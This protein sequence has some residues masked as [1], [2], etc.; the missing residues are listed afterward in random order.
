MSRRRQITALLEAWM[1]QVLFGKSRRAGEPG[2]GSLTPA[3][4]SQGFLSW[5]FA[6]I[7]FEGS[8]ARAFV[9]GTLA[10]VV[11]LSTIALVGELDDERERPADRDLVRSGPIAPLT[12]V[13]AR[14]LR[15]ALVTVLYSGG[16]AIAPAI[17]SG[18]K[19][20]DFFVVPIGFIASACLLSSAMSALLG[21]TTR[22][23][24][25]VIGA[26]RASS[27]SS[28]VRAALFGGG[29][30]AILL[31]MRAMLSNTSA[32]PGGRALLELLPMTWCA[33]AM[34]S[35]APRDLLLALAFP[36]ATA[37]LVL[38][39][40]RLSPRSEGGTKRKR[41]M[42]QFV[43]RAIVTDP[44]RR[45]ITSFCLAMLS[46]ER[47]FRLRALPLLGLPAA[48][49]LIALRADMGPDRLPWFLALIH[50]LP[51][52]YLPFLL[53]FAPYAEQPRASWLV[54]LHVTN[55]LAA[56]RRG[57]EIAF[58]VLCVPVQLVLLV[59]DASL[60]ETSVALF[61]T[62]GSL[63]IA[64]LALPLSARI[65]TRP[66]FAEDP[67]ELELPS[68]FGSSLG[69]A[70]AATGAA[71]ALEA[72]MRRFGPWAALGIFALGAGVLFARA[73]GGAPATRE[74]PKPSEI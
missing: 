61:T 18:F 8:S 69:F 49:V 64:W 3:V 32:F 38:L 9:A 13:L 54:E 46:R 52:A 11:L 31:G 5:G 6:A 71:F 67:D 34:L 27:F 66:A 48:A 62:L 58:A 59:V 7:A 21:A 20:G 51:L 33:D 43:L 29:F 56:Y 36:A 50:Q 60:R 70:V 73:R 44:K 23:I 22:T 42:L 53:W 10:F 47:S 16:L 19:T 68:D 65:L 45:G 72:S 39:T 74:S 55:P 2:S 57:L 40:S 24:A 37:L 12:F 28:F 63:G 14:W 1:I 4:F 35:W 41:S 25:A 30:V 26:G 15:Q 17:L